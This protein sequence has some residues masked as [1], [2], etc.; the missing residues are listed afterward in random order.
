MCD[1]E[2]SPNS[3]QP[4]TLPLYITA[5][6]TTEPKQQAYMPASK[7]DIWGWQFHCGP[8]TQPIFHFFMLQSK[9]TSGLDGPQPAQ[10]LMWP[11]DC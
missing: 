5:Q 4:K 7:T 6:K 2:C 1:I 8:A 3:A 10:A 11:R 9:D